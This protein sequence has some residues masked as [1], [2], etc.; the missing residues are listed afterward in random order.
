MGTPVKL[1]PYRVEM[2]YRSLATGE[3]V[4]WGLKLLGVPDLWKTT[5]GR[6][7]KVAVLDTGCQLGHPDLTGAVALAQN[8]TR[9]GDRDVQGHGTHVAGTIAARRNERGVVGVAPDCELLVA[10]VL[11]DDGNGSS[12]N[13]AAGVRWAVQHGAAIVSMSL[14]S[15]QPAEDIAEAIKDAVAKG[16]FVICAAGNEGPGMNTVN[17]PARLPETIAVAAVDRY[18][19]VADYSSRGPQ[20]DIAAPGSDVLSTWNNSGYSRISGTSMATPFVSG[21]VA[22]VLSAAKAGVVPQPSGVD[23]LRKLL[24]EHATDLGPSGRD[25]AS[26]FGLIAPGKMLAPSAAE[27]PHAS[28][29][30][31]REQVTINGQPFD[32]VLV[33]RGQEIAFP[34]R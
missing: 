10:K 7:I 15:P 5:L 33:P 28:L 30:G 17:Y 26:G 25:P 1:P 27:S 21:I 13:V 12:A 24:A 22:L 14:G 11:G 34:E 31:T 8:F 3:Q 18:G 2:V 9:D 20:V 32:W 16:V 23:G 19:R 29:V 4:D 6:G